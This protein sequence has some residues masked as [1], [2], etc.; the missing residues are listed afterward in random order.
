MKTIVSAGLLSLFLAN[1]VFGQASEP[2]KAVECRQ[3]A[4]QASK[5]LYTKTSKAVTK[6]G[7]AKEAR[8]APLDELSIEARASIEVKKF[9]RC[10]SERRSQLGQT[11]R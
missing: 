2:I 10:L 11:A 3:A 6:V 8:H 5:D 1:Q 4:Q 7:D 9:L